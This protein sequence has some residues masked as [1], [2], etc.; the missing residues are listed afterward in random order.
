LTR[1]GE[2]WRVSN[3]DQAS[4]GLHKRA[5]IAGP[6]TDAYYGRLFH[7]YGTVNPAHSA[8]LRKQAERG[9][10]G[11]PLWLWRVDQPVLAD[12]EVS[13]EIL[14]DN[15]LVLYA[16]PGS[17][18]LLSRIEAQLPIRVEADAVVVGSQRYTDK[19]V[20][21]KFI[22]PNPL[23]PKR[24]VIVLAAPSL[25]A[26]KAGYN[27]PDFL[28]DYVV[29]DAK[30]TRAR[31]R[32]LFPAAPPA[33]GYFDQAW[34]LDHTHT[35]RALLRSSLPDPR[36]VAQR[37]GNDPESAALDNPP[38]PLSIPVAPEAPAQPQ[39]F[40]TEPTSQ[41]GKA[42]REIAR[43]VATFSNFR[44]LIA[45]AT[46]RT[47]QASVWS[48]REGETCLSDLNERGVQ[49]QP[50]K[51]ALATP[52]ATPVQLRA[53]V[54]GVTFRF[55]HAAAGAVISCE[56][57]TRLRDIAEIVAHHG[58]HT[59]WVMSAYRDHP[60]PSFHTLGL[61]LDLSR[62]D[63]DAG[64]L[65]VQS[66]FAIDR[67]RQTC[68]EVPPNKKVSD[69]HRRLQA[70]ACELAAS[71]RFSSVLTPNYNAGHHDHFHIDIRPDDPRLFI[72]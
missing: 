35:Q 59:V 63:S 37:D 69:K 42:A 47:D 48:I 24:Y 62:F 29:Y 5:G 52:V 18:T 11:W 56:L 64:P 58:V 21:T 51:A 20:G 71:R 14:R 44:K 13:D 8:E 33:L 72:R 27:L 15:N 53:A 31:P 3:P 38:S 43:R 10:R 39:Q 19:G 41:A 66:D 2:H 49:V 30:T 23:N 16:T 46:W 60:Y 68:D 25:D 12:T 40:A 67:A 28:P 26:V 36:Q 1:D 50:W 7:V 70:I 54:G 65:V 17:H 34:Q 32:L 45:G 55:M 4:S 57:A 22:Y 61:A 9:A 6:I